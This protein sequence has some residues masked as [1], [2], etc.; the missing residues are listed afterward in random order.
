MLKF[1][2]ERE[3]TSHLR[4]QKKGGQAIGSC[5]PRLPKGGQR[6]SALSA[7]LIES[8]VAYGYLND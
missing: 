6:H 2:R 7:R 5:L 4:I 3:S 1:Q 8:E